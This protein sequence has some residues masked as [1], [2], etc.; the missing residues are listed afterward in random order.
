MDKKL[1]LLAKKLCDTIME[2]FGEILS[3]NGNTMPA[4]VSEDSRLCL[5]SAASRSIMII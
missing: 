5:K 3:K 4:C 1:M 2:D